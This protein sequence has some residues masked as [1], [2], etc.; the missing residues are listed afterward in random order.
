[1]EIKRVGVIGGRERIPH[2]LVDTCHFCHKHF[3]IRNMFIFGVF[4]K[5]Q[6]TVVHIDHL[7]QERTD[8][9]ICNLCLHNLLQKNLKIKLQIYNEKAQIIIDTWKKY[10]KM[11][12][13]SM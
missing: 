13:N 4:W 6:N 1:M 9:P 11:E 10:K 5:L 7:Y 8:D 12:I 2:T 3:Q